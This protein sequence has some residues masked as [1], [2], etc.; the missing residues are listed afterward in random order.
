MIVRVVT[1]WIKPRNVHWRLV[2]SHVVHI[3]VHHKVHLARVQFR[4]ETLDVVV[5]TEVA[6]QGVEVTRPVAIR[7]TSSDSE[8]ADGLL[9]ANLPMI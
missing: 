9:M 6:V 2:R 5:A 3:E 8:K 7:F 4:N 1:E